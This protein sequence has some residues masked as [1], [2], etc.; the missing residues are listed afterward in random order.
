MGK[1]H[2]FVQDKEE[3]AQGFRANFKYDPVI[4]ASMFTKLHNKIA[5]KKAKSEEILWH[6]DRKGYDR[7]DMMNL[8]VH[9]VSEGYSLV[10][11]CEDGDFPGVHEVR[12]WYGNHPSF[13][14]DLEEAEK[15][16]GEILGEAALQVAMTT[17]NHTVASDKLRYEALSKAAARLNER[18]QDKQIVKTEDQTNRMTDEQIRERLQSIMDANPELAEIINPIL[19]N[20]VEG[21]GRE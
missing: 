20:K 2:P 7:Y 12:S 5:N 14:R 16:R 17:T 13:Q 10:E 18:Y 11:V 15:T 21:V 3:R 19:S 1:V 8:L 9:L 4:R 6:I